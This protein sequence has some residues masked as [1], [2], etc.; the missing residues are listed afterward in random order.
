MSMKPPAFVTTSWDDGDPLD[1]K[2]AEVLRSRDVNGTFY[3]PLQ[4]YRREILSHSR[5]RA[6]THE[7]FEIG[8]HSVSHK[9]LR[10]LSHRELAA[11]IAPCKPALE[12]ILGSE[13]RMFSYPQGRYDAN[14]VRVLKEAGYAGA[15]TVRMLSTRMDFDRFEMPTTVQSFPHPPF[16]YFRNAA[17]AGNVEGLRTCLSE[18][19][20]LRN[21][22]VLGKRLFDLVLEN[23]GVW[24]L[25][26]HSWEL[27]KL[28]LWDDLAELL[29]YVSRRPGVSY[30][31]NSELVAAPAVLT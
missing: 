21:W 15:R 9:I 13:V 23:G 6:L 20:G 19:F 11:E 30:V 18:G 17:K 14:A 28:R 25:Y 10:G 24:H 26:G 16:T 1:L 2:L 27:E 12:D 3:V 4:A 31:A 29:D 5:M 7:G 22:V 8:A